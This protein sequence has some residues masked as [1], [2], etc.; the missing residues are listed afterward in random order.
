[1]SGFAVDWTPEKRIAQLEAENAALRL[2]VDTLK[3]GGCVHDAGD[4]VLMM[5]RDELDT[6]RAD[7]TRATAE[8][9][10]AF[11][12]GFISA[13]HYCISNY[14][15]GTPDAAWQAWREQKETA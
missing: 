10:A 1:M 13:Q 6:L 4:G 9:E 5:R 2:A 12:A 15:H 3:G 7:L 14:S 8:V 11:R